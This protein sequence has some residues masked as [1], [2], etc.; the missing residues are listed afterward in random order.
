MQTFFRRENF[1]E[2]QKVF[3][4]PTHFCNFCIPGQLYS[5][6]GAKPAGLPAKRQP[7]VRRRKGKTGAG[8]EQTDT[9][10]RGARSRAGKS[11]HHTRAQEAGNGT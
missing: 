11:A 5:S 6:C 1:P 8:P 4:A 10:A 7:G 2:V 9:Y 3:Y